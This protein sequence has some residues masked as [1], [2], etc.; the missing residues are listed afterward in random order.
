M[1]RFTTADCRVVA[2]GLDHPESIVLDLQGNL[3]T[4]GEAGQIYR[5]A[6]DGSRV[7]EYANSGGE[8]GGLALDAA[9]NLYEC[10]AETRRV[11]LITPGGDITVYSTGTEDLPVIY[12]NYPVF[13]SVGNLFYTDSGNWQKMN[14]RLFV[15]RPGGTTEVVIPSLLSFPNAIALD[16]E[17]GWLYMVQTTGRNVIRVR[18]TDGRVLG[19]PEIYVSFSQDVLPDGIALAES[20]N[21]YVACYEPDVIYVVE[22]N[23]RMEPLLEGLDYGVFNRATG[24]AFDLSSPDLYYTNYGGREIGALTVGERGMPTSH[25]SL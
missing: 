22:P 3:Y 4:S 18:V 16:E 20:G 19:D 2:T 6:P 8:S 25:P 7:E 1:S 5:I 12:P 15:V 14:G 11:N 13:D 23:R 24:I 9:G 10:N 21:L 17:A